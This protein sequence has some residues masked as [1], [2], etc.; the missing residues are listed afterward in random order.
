MTPDR[1]RRLPLL[2]LLSLLPVATYFLAEGLLVVS[3]ALVNVV[4]VVWVL[5]LFFRP[6]EGGEGAHGPDA[7]GPTGG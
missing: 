6:A 4:L 2:G 7:E 1:T 3:L 5:R